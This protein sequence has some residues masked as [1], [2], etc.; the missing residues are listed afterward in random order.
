LSLA[1]A[2]GPRGAHAAPLDYAL[3]SKEW[4]GLGRLAEEARAAGCALVARASLDWDALVPTDVLWFVYPRSEIDPVKLRRFLAAG[5]RAVVADDFGAAAEA[6][7]S[8]G[9]RRA[10]E[11]RLGVGVARYLDNPNLPVARAGLGTPLGRSTETLVANH[12]ASFSTVL[13][14]TFAFAPGAA[15][16]VEGRLGAGRFVAIA[17][18]SMLINNMLE[19]AQNGA[20]A[21]ALV[22][23]TCRSARDR[24]L[25][26]TGWFR[27]R[28][29]PPD[30]LRDDPPAPA[31]ERFNQMVD[32][33]N[34]GAFDLTVDPTGAA[35]LGI[36]ACAALLLLVLST[37]PRADR[38][39]PIDGHWTR[40]RTARGQTERPAPG[41]E[42]GRPPLL[43]LREE[44][45]ERVREAL[46]VADVRR[47]G[48]REIGRLIEATW[49]RVAGERATELW[50][51]C[52]ELGDPEGPLPE[53]LEV[54]RAQLERLHAL[55]AA[56]FLVMDATLDEAE[57]GYGHAD[58]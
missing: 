1:L 44:V 13:P 23:D 36:V 58:D 16:V 54:S 26:Y 40:A 48:P 43:L 33:L 18:P 52:L 50:R 14:P 27:S 8:L 2:V 19:L 20:F 21:R 24:V 35:V 12:P 28:G 22:T 34:R 6:L 32:R 3:D 10:A 15:L 7:A 46:G 31:V 42:S 29:E 39:Y 41:W 17:D 4:N 5:G 45:F 49:G 11:A 57:R 37:F 53:E 9:V 30:A 56:L 25:L 38:A 55:A 47:R 51:A